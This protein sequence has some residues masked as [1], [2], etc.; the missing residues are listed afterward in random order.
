MSHIATGLYK[1]Y[2]GLYKQRFVRTLDNFLKHSIHYYS[3]LH[4][5]LYFSFH[6]P[7]S[8][9]LTF[10]ATQKMSLSGAVLVSHYMFS[11]P[12]DWTHLE[13]SVGLA[14]VKSLDDV[15]SLKPEPSISLW[16]QCSQVSATVIIPF[17]SDGL[18]EI[19]A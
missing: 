14:V 5:K 16:S 6:D 13:S 9:H 1:P 10:R 3:N 12:L 18:V 17:E 2:F 19:R 4:I 15:A 8:G 11:T 7:T